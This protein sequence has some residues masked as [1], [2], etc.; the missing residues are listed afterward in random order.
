MKPL[1]IFSLFLISGI[2]LIFPLMGQEV[3]SLKAGDK[4][5]LF[6]AIDDNNQLW[7]IKDYIGKKNIVIYFFPAAMTSGCTKQACSYRDS[8]SD[9]EKENS[10]VVGI[11]GD[12][13]DNLKLF[14]KA[15]N[16][17]FT[18]LSDNTGEIARKFGVPLGEGNSITREIDGKEF[19]LKRGVTAKR[20]TFTVN[21]KGEI[22][23]IDQAVDAEND[24]QNVLKILRV[25]E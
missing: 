19:I 8:Y 23:N 7:N 5:P 18:L 22:I 13:I 9:L 6:T 21:K 1:R 20:W 10:L 25:L 16:L 12:E 4:V 3:R 15:Y 24:S 14:K 11:S 2:L 17:N